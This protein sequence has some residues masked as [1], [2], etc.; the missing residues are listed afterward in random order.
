MKNPKSTKTSK[1]HS[2]N[3]MDDPL[4]NVKDTFEQLSSSFFDTIHVI[5]MGNV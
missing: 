3:T 4:N 1:L 5:S 2:N